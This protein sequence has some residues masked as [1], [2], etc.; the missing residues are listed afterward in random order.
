MAWQWNDNYYR[1]KLIENPY[2]PFFPFLFAAREICGWE[3]RG[4]L[5]SGRGPYVVDVDGR[6][7]PQ[8]SIR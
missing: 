4:R 6:H 2:H 1:K 3:V 7:Y 8:L 5:I